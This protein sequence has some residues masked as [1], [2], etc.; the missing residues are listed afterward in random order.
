MYFR[1]L[2]S[3]KFSL[4]PPYRETLAS[5]LALM[6]TSLSDV[7]MNAFAAA[8][9]CGLLL[10]FENALPFPME[11]GWNVVS[12]PEMPCRK[13]CCCKVHC[14]KAVLSSLC[15][16]FYR[17]MNWRTCCVDHLLCGKVWGSKDQCHLRSK[18]SHKRSL[19]GE[20][21]ERL[22]CQRH[23]WRGPHRCCLSASCC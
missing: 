11:N 14:L 17:R 10:N 1:Y 3:I 19:T 9:S 13:G 16:K 5:S 4:L 15:P 2:S 12:H 23:S 20:R 22:K 8:L 18:L 7:T 6:I 21:A